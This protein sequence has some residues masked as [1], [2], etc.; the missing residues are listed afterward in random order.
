MLSSYDSLQYSAPEP[1]ADTIP[2]TPSLYPL[3]TMVYC[4]VAVLVLLN[5]APLGLNEFAVSIVPLLSDSEAYAIRF[6]PIA[7]CK[8]RELLIP[9]RKRSAGKRLVA[10]KFIPSISR[11]VVVPAR[12]VRSGIWVSDSLFTKRPD[13]NKPAAQ[14]RGKPDLNP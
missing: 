11:S 3:K 6:C 10:F 13:L 12:N 4:P 7:D 5:P 8:Y 2:V 9:T 1:S 14:I